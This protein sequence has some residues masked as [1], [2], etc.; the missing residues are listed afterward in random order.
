M[1]TIEGNSVL[2]SPVSGSK[3]DRSG[4]GRSGSGGTRYHRIRKAIHLVCFLIF[5]VLPF[6]NV[7]RFDI[8]RQRFHFFGYELWIS[9]FGILFFTL[10]FLMFLIVVTAMLYG[11]FFCGYLCPQM[12]F[13]EA[14]I[15]LEYR[16]RRMIV[17][18][19]VGWSSGHRDL[20]VRALF[21]GIIGIASVFLAFVFVSY[22]VEPLDL[23]RRLAS[24]DLKTAGGIS[25]AS[26]TLI[27]FLDFTLVRQRFCTTVCP[28]GYLQGMLTD[29][30]TLLVQYRDAGDE[31]IECKKCV[32]VC[33]MGID[34]RNSPYQ[35]ECIHCGECIDACSDILGKLGKKGLIH[36][37]W[38]EAGEL[39]SDKRGPWY[40]RLG[41]RDAKRVAIMLVLLFYAAG[42]FAALSMRHSVLVRLNPDRSTLYRL[43]EDGRIYNTFR[44][45]LANR[46]SRR[47]TVS[48]ALES[49]P[50]AQM[51]LPKNPM[52]L[53]PGE[54]LQ[55]M[56]EIS[57]SRFPGARDVNHFRVHAHASPDDTEEIFDVTFLMPP[58][59]SA[60]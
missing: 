3:N 6:S 45:N 47:Q 19:T 14:S 30:N 58:E 38:G 55:E 29:G 50:D 40:R 4:S 54:Q 43:G 60:K 1:A 59:R 41:L 18:R 17:K 46:S 16:L 37:A 32:R 24:L 23:L 21:Y 20:A 22:F 28:Y 15:A 53:E 48:L 56:F 31:C 57:A 36:Y 25:G 39:L 52:S 34:I 10:M 35:I 26:V 11:R 33:H 49:L 7:L 5:V 9:E 44:L 51:S 42:L 13:S 2:K 27:T 8:P 12:I